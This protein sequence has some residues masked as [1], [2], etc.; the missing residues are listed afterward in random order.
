MLKKTNW[1]PQGDRQSVELIHWH[2]GARGNKKAGGFETLKGDKIRLKH[3]TCMNRLKGP[4]EP[5]N[6]IKICSKRKRCFD[7]V[8]ERKVHESRYCKKAEENAKPELVKPIGA[9]FKKLEI[10]LRCKRCHQ[11]LKSVNSR[12][13]HEDRYCG[14]LKA[15]VTR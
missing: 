11:K 9:E 2:G 3:L 13:V 15:R 1:I 8:V 14:K 4:P 6:E 5:T 7:T 10:S 12:K